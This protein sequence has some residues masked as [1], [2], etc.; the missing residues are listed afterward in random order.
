MRTQTALAGVCA[1]EDRSL[2]VA[3]RNAGR[4][5][6]LIGEGAGR[7]EPHTT[8]AI[9]LNAADSPVILSLARFSASATASPSFIASRRSK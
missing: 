7:S 4:R 5:S 3:V 9:A 1:A 6:G 2:T 8:P